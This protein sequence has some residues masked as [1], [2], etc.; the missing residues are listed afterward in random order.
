MS[1]MV[2]LSKFDGILEE[3]SWIMWGL[4]GSYGN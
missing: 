1:N 4:A 3:I 2:I